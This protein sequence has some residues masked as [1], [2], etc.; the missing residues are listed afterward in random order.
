MKIKCRLS[1]HFI[2]G[3]FLWILSMGLTIMITIEVIFPLFGVTEDNKG[4]DF[5][6]FYWIAH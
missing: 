1:F 5:F 6:V 4:Y 3:L 2:F